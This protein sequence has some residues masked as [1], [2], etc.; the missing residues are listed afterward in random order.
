M[1]PAARAA[2]LKA[3][4]IC[5]EQLKQKP[6]DA[7]LHVHLAK[8]LAWLGEKDA[9]FSEAQRATQICGRKAKMHSRVRELPRRLQRFMRSSATMLVR[10]SFW[11]AY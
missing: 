4:N 9:A 3:K 11:T 7:D 6:D 8:L 1:R 2:L 10:S 5:E